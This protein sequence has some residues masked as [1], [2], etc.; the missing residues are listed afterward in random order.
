MGADTNPVDF[1]E[2]ALNDARKFIGDMT[3]TRQHVRTELLFR[4]FESLHD[5]VLED[6]DFDSD[7]ILENA[8]EIGK[9]EILL[10]RLG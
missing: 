1:Q 7:I 4:K 3:L 5:A 2:Q 8:V 9:I 10:H 6:D